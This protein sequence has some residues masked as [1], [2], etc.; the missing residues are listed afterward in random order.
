MDA[1]NSIANDLFFKVRSRFSG[2]KLGDQSGMVTINPEDARFFDF[3]YKDGD[4]PIGHITISLAEPNS[5]KVYFS[6]GISESM[7]GDQKKH[8]YGFL[9]E[10][11]NFAKRRL[12]AFDTRDIA[13]DN[14]DKRDYQFLTTISQPKAAS[15]TIVKPVGENIMSESQLYGTKTVSYQN[16]MDTRLIIKHNQTLGDDLQP[17][18]RSRNISALFVEN[19]DGE[20]FKYPFIHLAGARAMQRHVANGGLPYDDVGKSII[21]MS[22]NIAQ[23]R[24]FSNYVVRNDLMNSDNNPII[25]R[26][27]EALNNLREQIARLSKQKYYEDYK[28]S[29][30]AEQEIDLPDSVVED[31]KDKFTVKNFKEDIKSVFPILYRLMQENS[32]VGYEDIVS[33]TTENE[34]ENIEIREEEDELLKFER[35]IMTMGEESS[36]TSDDPEQQNQAIKELQELVGDHF[37]AGVD[38]TNAIESLKGIIE[39][40]QLFKQ[41][42]DQAKEDPDSCVRPLVKDWLEKNAPEVVSEL[43][44]GDMVDEPAAGKG[45]EQ[46]APEEEPQMAGD[47][48]D[49]RNKKD[50][51]DDLPFEPDDDPT[52]KDE[53]GNI[54][55]HKARHLARK[56]M[57]QAM[58]VKEL[59]EFITS[60]Y[61]K[62][63][64]TFPKGPEGVC[65]MVGKKFGEQ[66]EAVA[67]KFVE[68]M[69]PH[70][71]QGAEKMQELARI[72]ELAGMKTEGDRIRDISPEDDP[73]DVGDSFYDEDYV[74]DLASRVFKT[75]PNLSA[76]GRGDEVVDAAYKIMVKELGRKRADYILRHDE[77]F[78]GDLLDT[79]ARAQH[80]RK[81][82]GE[83]VDEDSDTVDSIKA[84]IAELEDEQGEN[85]FGSYA[86]DTADAELQSLYAKLD[87]AK[88]GMSEGALDELH[89]DLNDKFNE[90]APKIEKYKDA[91]GAKNLYDELMSIAKGYGAQREFERMLD[92]ARHHAHMEYDTNPGG[93]E[94]WFWHLPLGDNLKDDVSPELE[95]IR[96]LSGIAQGIGY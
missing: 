42:K 66:A 94:N 61:D 36:I 79:Y 59:A 14:L 21:K 72:R 25:E 50:D 22:E 9:Q 67:R 73:D 95:D 53:F 93:F 88:K 31:F 91:E 96:R 71:E 54:I 44:F 4:K 11:R 56:G 37:P 45:G 33:M 20:R 17:G 63:S 65:T 32:K 8:W 30:V 47:D 82:K 78:T 85:E 77:D 75:N 86:Y 41:I 74:F 49:E 38:G 76:K 6:S 28:N 29:F 18:A 70:Q 89:S 62:E 58:D 80:H 2:L 7:G 43:D 10:L 3:D 24:S 69:A 23:L 26:S 52:D 90:L 87:K 40:P 48:P 15:D 5:M 39:D 83:G 46:T 13:K 68:R 84:K 55:K 34:E 60:F 57:R 51:K 92:N 12:M 35:W 19:Q 16:L 1:T 64:G 81:L 27:Q